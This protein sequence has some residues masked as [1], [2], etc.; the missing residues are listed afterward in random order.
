MANQ[1]REQLANPLLL[2]LYVRP[3]TIDPELAQANLAV[4]GIVNTLTGC[5]YAAYNIEIDTT[6]WV[7]ASPLPIKYTAILAPGTITPRT[8]RAA[9][10]TMWAGWRNSL[11]EQFALAPTLTPAEFTARV[12]TLIVP[13]PRNPMPPAKVA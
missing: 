2:G 3:E 10:T 12:G 8:M 13:S 1:A 5:A 9:R 4:R 7:E 11:A 6:E